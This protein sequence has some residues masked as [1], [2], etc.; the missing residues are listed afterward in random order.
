MRYSV[1]VIIAGLIIW[2][3]IFEARSGGRG[4]W[5]CEGLYTYHI[6]GQSLIYIFGILV[7][8]QRRNENE[9][10]LK[11][12]VMILPLVLLLFI[13]PLW[14]YLNHIKADTR[15]LTLGPS[16]LHLLWIFHQISWLIWLLYYGLIKE[17]KSISSK[18]RLRNS[19]WFWNRLIL[20]F[21]CG[22]IFSVACGFEVYDGLSIASG[23]G[24]YYLYARILEIDGILTVLVL[25][26]AVMCLFFR[27]YG[28]QCLS[29]GIVLVESSAMFYLVIEID[30]HLSEPIWLSGLWVFGT[31][32]VS[33]GVYIGKLTWSSID[34]PDSADYPADYPS[35]YY[36]ILVLFLTV[37]LKSFVDDQSGNPL[38][39]W[40]TAKDANS[41]I[42]LGVG[43]IILGF[44]Y[45]ESFY[46]RMTVYF[47]RLKTEKHNRYDRES[48]VIDH[49]E[50]L[51]SRRNI[52]IICGKGDRS[53]TD[54]VDIE[55][56]KGAIGK[57]RTVVICARDFN[58]HKSAMSA[59]KMLRNLR[60]KVIE[61]SVPEDINCREK[62]IGIA[63]NIANSIETAV[64]S[65]CK[66]FFVKLTAQLPS[67]RWLQRR[68]DG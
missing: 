63:V 8:I 3:L 33:C 4:E 48:E 66:W 41:V 59:A 12:I 42:F 22:A 50:L 36:S 52:R 45:S 61:V 39:S 65:N 5:F 11:Q 16:I 20:G 68:G 26:C 64:D 67:R 57:Y 14:D 18:T 51:L 10:K 56:L 53:N 7:L 2:F 30:Q 29:L 25:T 62:A 32:L 55:R 40:E 19:A 58:K 1:F 37:I 27:V 43:L 24:E 17:I 49:I 31:F 13:D 34:R 28:Y 6:I 54:V 15:K 9:G 23:A 35:C 47:V 44:I 38:D 21:S 46:T 60:K